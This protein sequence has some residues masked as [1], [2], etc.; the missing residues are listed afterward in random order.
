MIHI[1]EYWIQSLG[2]AILHSLWLGFAAAFF[3]FILLNLLKNRGA[4]I[5]YVSSVL[6]LVILFGSIGFIFFDE[7]RDRSTNVET[8]Y[9]T[10]PAQVNPPVL[11]EVKISFLEQLFSR[12]SETWNQWIPTVVEL[13][14]WGIL[15]FALRLGVGYYGLIR[16]SRREVQLPPEIWLTRLGQLA[17]EA[18]IRRVVNM[19]ISGIA[20]GPMTLWHLRPLI[21][22]PA[23]MLSGMSPDH[24]E[25]IIIHE[26]AHI[27]RADFLVN[28]IQTLIETVLFYHP[29]LWWI[30]GRIRDL[31]EEC[32][33]DRVL[34]TGRDVHIYAEALTRV[35][36]FY[37]S[38]KTM[39]MMSATGN[40]GHFT[41]RIQ[42]MFGI[43]RR[44]SQPG[45]TL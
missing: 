20:D 35:Y 3:L 32:C 25:A 29:A 23:G 18:G 27:R 22:I 5:K 14:F 11:P 10:G 39:F 12:V 30:S 16:L 15:L 36:A 33:D 31:R 9:E 43:T 40:N 44:T 17:K 41:A 42:R 6:T 2:W 26:L 8:T 4:E 19:R 7:Y 37:H 21:L 13:W 1:A 38:P 34:A 24:I 28:F 45:K